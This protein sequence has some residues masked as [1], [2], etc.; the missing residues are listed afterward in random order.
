MN[1]T[2]LN[3]YNQLMPFILSSISTSLYIPVSSDLRTENLKQNLLKA[4]ENIIKKNKEK[5]SE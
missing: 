3:N 5:V 1:S 2:D 4:T